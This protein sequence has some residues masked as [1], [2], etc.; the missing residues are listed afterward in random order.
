MRDRS[1]RFDPRERGAGRS[2]YGKRH[3][4][5]PRA[6]F[7][8]E[9][10]LSLAM[11][12]RKLGRILCPN[13]ETEWMHSHA[14]NPVADEVDDH[15]VRIYFSTRDAA[16]RSSVAWVEVDMRSPN[17][18]ARMAKTPT[19]SPGL[20][21]C[22]DD[23]GCSIGSIIREGKQRLMYYMGWNLSVTVPW[24]NS[25]G[26]AVSENAGET[27]ERVSLAP[28]VDRSDADPYTI[29][30]PWVLRDERRMAYVVRLQ[31]AVGRDEGRTCF[32]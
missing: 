21:G 26:L 16:N 4:T 5:F 24:R 10:N 18:V 12:W 32:I 20:V 9:E 13:R 3:R 25:I 29:S 31:S 28:I 27:F 14:A 8:I 6:E 2:I 22:F 23:S 11:K 19:L 17:R 7:P 30:Y 1:R 15:F